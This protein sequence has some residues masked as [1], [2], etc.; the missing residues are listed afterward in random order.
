MPELSEVE[1]QRL[2][3]QDRTL[4][5][6]MGNPKAKKKILEAYKAA[7][8]EASI[9]ELEIEEAAKAP[10][11]ALEKDIADL[12]KQLA[13]EKAENEKNAKLAKLGD[14]IESGMT[15]LRQAGWF[16]EDLK[17]LREVM[18]ERGIVDVDIA[19]AYYE[20]QHPPQEVVTPRGV[21]GWNFIDN[22]QDGEKDLQK[23]LETKG[24]SEVLAD[25]MARDALN[26]H[27]GTMRR[28][29]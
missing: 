29:S 22:V 17:K 3:T 6:L 8:P 7:N 15:K 26:E 27:R 25:K 2:Q 1:I 16:D 13:D 21:G 19:A 12:K 20:K 28:Q 24:N 23:L 5:S 14:S 18:D 9:P 10:V 4:H 11:M